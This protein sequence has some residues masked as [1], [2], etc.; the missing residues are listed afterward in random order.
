MT[1]LKY[2]INLIINKKY[3]NLSKCNEMTLKILTLITPIHIIIPHRNVIKNHYHF[4]NIKLYSHF[5]YKNK[6]LQ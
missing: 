6:I 4:L 2:K 3:D 5:H 1:I